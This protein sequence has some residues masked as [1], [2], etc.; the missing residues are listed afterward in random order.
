VAKTISAYDKDVSDEIY[1][2]ATRYVSKERLLAMLD[3]EYS[4]LLERLNAARGQE[5]RFFVFADT[6]ATRNYQGTNEQHG[7]LGI[8]F[9]AETR[10]EPSQIL[11]HINLCD[12]TV[13]LQQQAIGILGVNLIYAA[14][15]Q[16][17]RMDTFLE[18]LSTEWSL[19]LL[20]R[21]M[22]HAIVFG[23]GGSLLSQRASCANGRCW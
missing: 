19:A 21:K 3:W 15:H 4:L 7:W 16:G 20:S 10:S 1:G 17:S 23:T 9:Q 13:Q 6:M 5:K 12:S 8:R 11:L 14:F 22:G 2:A 18:G